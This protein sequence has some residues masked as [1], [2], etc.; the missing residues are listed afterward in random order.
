[1]SDNP[2]QPPSADSQIVGIKSGEPR[3]LKSVAKFQKGLLFS[4]LLQLIVVISSFSYY[5]SQSIPPNNFDSIVILLVLVGGISGTFFVFSMAIKVYNPLAGVLLGLLTLIPC[6]GLI[7]LAAVNGKAT[8]ILK[9][10][11]IKVGFL[12]AKLSQI[13]AD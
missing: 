2:Y 11:G 3:D 7:N 1:M 13:Q 4:I 5:R 6:I 9:Q 8:S 10:N 12:G